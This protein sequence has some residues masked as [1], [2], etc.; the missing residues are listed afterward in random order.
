LFI[1]TFN[2]YILPNIYAAPTPIANPLCDVSINFYIP[3]FFAHSNDIIV[4]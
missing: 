4:D 1:S 3:H 2:A